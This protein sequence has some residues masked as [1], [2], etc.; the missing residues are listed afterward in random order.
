[1]SIDRGVPEV[2]GSAYDVRKLLAA[3]GHLR[4]GKELHLPGPGLIR[5]RLMK[6]LD[7]TQF[8]ELIHEYGLIG[9]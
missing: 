5:R 8:G 9:E 2:F 3:S 1:V 7:N 4:V 6:K